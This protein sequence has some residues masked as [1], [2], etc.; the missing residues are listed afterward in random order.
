MGRMVTLTLNDALYN[1]GI[2][3]FLRVCSR[4]GF[5]VQ[6]S[7]N[8]ISF[9][10]EILQNFTQHYLETLMDTFREDMVYAEMIN[11]W[12]HIR[13]TPTNTEA[14]AKIFDEGLKYIADKLKRNSYLAGYEIIKSRGESYDFQNAVK[15]IKD[16]PD[17]GQ[18]TILLKVLMEKVQRYEDVLLLKDIA[19]TRIQPFWTNV[20]FLNKNR[21]KAEFAVCFDEAFVKEAA[22]FVPREGKRATLQCCQCETAMSKRDSFALSWVNDVG[23]DVARKTSYF[24]DFNVDSFLCPV[25][26]LIY[27][28][29]PLGFYMKGLEG[30]FVNDN[31]SI[32]TLK[33]MNEIA[34]IKLQGRKDDLFYRV[35]DNFMQINQ[36]ITA[37]KEIDNIQIIRRTNSTYLS[38]ILSK[39]KLRII[40]D[41]QKDFENI[42]GLSFKVNDDYLNIYREVI[43]RI[44]T[45]RNLYSLMHILLHTGI[46]EGSRI[47]FV[48]SLVKIQAVAFSKG[49]EKM[50]GNAVYSA[51]KRGEELRLTMVGDDQNENKIRSLSYKLLNALRTRNSAD[52]M[53]AVLRNYIGLGKAMPVGFLDVLKDENQ[54]L[55]FGYAFVTGLNG[56]VSNAAGKETANQESEGDKG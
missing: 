1:A 41:Y 16:T 12:T 20:A 22:G 49:D 40:R 27:A 37:E 31:A 51:M 39:E 53:D 14:Y 29:L 35:I 21:N 2:L 54:F 44:L 32:L 3:G 6:E 9:D 36:T 48:R 5:A 15:K 30:I 33:Q 45:G 56:G 17:Y 24:W 11:Q 13:A 10:S 25:C 4:A 26:N 23:V 52:F 19:Y 55:E 43:Q 50:R 46:A 38:N 18:K 7:G 42:V 8:S 47:W 28:C 34:A